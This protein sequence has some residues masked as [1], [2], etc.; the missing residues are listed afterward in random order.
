MWTY[1]T[2]SSILVGREEKEGGRAKGQNQVARYF[3][4]GKKGRGERRRKFLRDFPWSRFS[5]LMREGE[6]GGG[7]EADGD[8]VHAYCI[9]PRP[10]SDAPLQKGKRKKGGG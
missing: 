4:S 7:A 3:C 6:K 10:V 2:F 5:L 8:Q 9:S 1:K